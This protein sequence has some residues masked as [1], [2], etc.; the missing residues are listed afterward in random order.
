MPA[1]CGGTRSSRASA[2]H[3]SRQA[4]R[5]F[6]DYEAD[7]LLRSAVERRFEIIGEALNHPARVDSGLANQIPERARIV[8]L[9]NVLIHGYAT[10]DNR[11][12]W[13]VIETSLARLG[14]ALD[15]LLA[16]N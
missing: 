12:V 8:A 7:E 9:R 14:A 3:D 2:S 16:Q 6:A 4:G 5:R 15:G 11:L 10:V 13:S 1:S